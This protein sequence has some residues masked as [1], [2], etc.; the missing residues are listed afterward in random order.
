MAHE[1][2]DEAGRFYAPRPGVPDLLHPIIMLGLLALGAVGVCMALPRAGQLN[3]QAIG[4][5][6]AATAGGLM[7]MALSWVATQMDGGLAN[8]PNLYFYL[9]SV[10]ALGGALRVVTHPRPVYAALFFV[11]T[12]L[13]SAGMYVLLD[14]EFMAF[15]LIIV[16]AGAILITYL[17]VIMLATQAPS[18]EQIDSLADYD[19]T[20]RE[21]LAGTIV[22]FLMLGVLTS[23]L[24]TTLGGGARGIQTRANIEAL[25]TPSQVPGTSDALL[26]TLPGRIE[27]SLRQ[28]RRIQTPGWV[29]GDDGPRSQWLP[30][31]RAEEKIASG[32]DGRALIDPA[33][34]MVTVADGQG[35]TREVPWPA[36]LRATNIEGVGRNLLAEHPGSIEIAGVILLMAMLGAVVLARKQV[37]LDEEAKAKQAAEIAE[38]RAEGGLGRATPDLSLASDEAPSPVAASVGGHR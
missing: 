37:D 18:E 23:M 12:I 36:D 8:L 20:A 5:V 34:R 28:N 15:A 29:D 4:G 9:F 31:I 3:L 24:F 2:D 33:R 32:P 22:G 14:A 21:P 7:I 26:A 10:I 27:K 30:T 1:V 16:Y 11:L 17:F 6:I 13:A 19:R 25:P 35:Q 38:R